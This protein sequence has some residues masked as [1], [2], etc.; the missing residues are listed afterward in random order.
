MIELREN[1]GKTLLTLKDAEGRMDVTGIVEASGL[2]HAAV[3]RAALTL[4]S[5]SLV[6][7][8]EKKSAKASLN[9]EGKRYAE[10][11]LPERRL[12]DALKSMGG[13]APVESVLDAASLDRSL[14]VIALGWLSRK[15]WAK[16][17]KKAQTL[18]LLGEPSEGADEE[19]L[20][21]LHEKGTVVVENL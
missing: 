12:V 14:S 8:L 16:I 3:M 1:E 21:L 2:A 11:G 18:K 6:K 13:E 5:K 9:D 10:G 15:G 17:E 7:I 20:S 4:E 19:L